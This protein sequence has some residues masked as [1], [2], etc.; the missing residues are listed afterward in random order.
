MV[1]R[2]IKKSERQA[3]QQNENNGEATQ[4]SPSP[5]RSTDRNE[6][7]SRSKDKGRGKGKDRDEKPSAPVNP[8]LM[9]GP[10]PVKPKPPVEE[11]SVAVEETTETEAAAESES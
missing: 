2:P 4:A 1:E 3:A 5:G 9:R 7:R 11:A 10:R 8:A 6:N